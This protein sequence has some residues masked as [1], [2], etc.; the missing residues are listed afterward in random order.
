MPQR[1]KQIRTIA[2]LTDRQKSFIDIL[3]DNWGQMSKSEALQKAGYSTKGSKQ[4]IAVIASRLTNPKLNPHVCRYLEMCLQ[5][6]QEKYEKD[7][8]RRYKIFE[9]LRNG[10]ETK[11]QYTG[12]INAE[13]RAGQLAGQFV[14]KKEI[15]HTTLEGMSRDKLEERLKELENKIKDA[16]NIIDVTPSK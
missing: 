4:S 8:L 12:A 13:F 6:E 16:D 5:Q 10:A 11:G 15:A 14:D 7:K 9:R 2:D 1:P 3:V